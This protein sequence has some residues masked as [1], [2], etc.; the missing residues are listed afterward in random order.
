VYSVFLAPRD[1]EGSRYYLSS[2]PETNPYGE[3]G[4]I[5]WFPT[6]GKEKENIFPLSR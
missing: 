2:R 6:S 4:E 5:S 3:E 1:S